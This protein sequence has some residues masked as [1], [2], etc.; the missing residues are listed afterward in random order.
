MLHRRD[1]QLQSRRAAFHYPTDGRSVAFTEADQPEKF[2]MDAARH[3]AKVLVRRTAV[4]GKGAFLCSMDQRELGALPIL[5]DGSLNE[6]AVLLLHAVSGVEVG[7]LREARIRPASSNWLHAPWYGYQR[8]GALTIGRTIWF[9]R[10]WFA[11][12]GLGDGSAES[13]RRWLLHLAHEVGHLTQ[14]EHFGRSVWAKV[15]YVATF[16]LQ[17]FERAILFKKDVHDIGL[18]READ[19][20]RNVLIALLGSQAEQHP[21]VAAVQRQD[22]AFVQ[23][24]CNSRLATLAAL[25][26]EFAKTRLA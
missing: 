8:G 21:L 4:W 1:I 15:R 20:G 6:A 25:R 16:A 7:L 24:W 9:T 12:D 17:Y 22:A 10:I 26:A 13:Y 19:L 5:P 23:T 11:R 3:A 14:A 18:E 2:T